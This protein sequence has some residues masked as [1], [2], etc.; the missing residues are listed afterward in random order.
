MSKTYY[1]CQKCGM[2][3][4]EVVAEDNDMKCHSC[5]NRLKEKES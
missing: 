3:F 5:G 1:A 2:M 4:A